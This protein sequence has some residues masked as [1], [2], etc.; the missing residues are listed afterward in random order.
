MLPSVG[1]MRRTLALLLLLAVGGCGST[2]QPG[3]N[4]G[5][6]SSAGGTGAGTGGSGGS[7]GGGGVSGSGGTA[8]TGG[9]G[10]HGGSSGSGGGGGTGGSGGAGCGARACTNSEL[11]VH[12]SCGGTAPQCNPLPDGGQCPSGWTYRALCNSGPQP[13]PGC[14]APPCTPPAPYCV[15]RPASCGSTV[16]CS[17]LPLNVCQGSGACGV[18]SGDNVLCVSA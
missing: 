14:E 1:I 18:I 10:G 7:G 6:G 16:T 9:V 2:A 13:G 8:G 15:T 11:C 17:C 3:V 4:G 12:P 5:G